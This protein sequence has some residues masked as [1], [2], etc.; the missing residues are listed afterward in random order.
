MVLLTTLVPWRP[1]PGWKIGSARAIARMPTSGISQA[2][3]FFHGIQK[4]KERMFQEAQAKP[5]GLR[6][7][8]R[9]F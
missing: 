4:I 6:P 1:G 9:S 2:L 7:S 5:S 3:N 8:L